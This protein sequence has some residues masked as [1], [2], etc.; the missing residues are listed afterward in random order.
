MS[1]Y[2]TIDAHHHFWDPDNGDYSWMSAAH[3]PIRRVFAPND[4]QP[5]LA[6]AG[7][8]KTI[9]V[10][11]WSSIDETLAFLKIAQETD[12]IAGVVGWLDLTAKD[13]SGRL[14]W[15]LARP[16]GKWLVGIRHQVHDEDDPNWLLRDDVRRGLS[17]IEAC[18]LTYDLLIRPRELSASL[19]TVRAF[20]GLRFVVDHIAKP[21]IGRGEFE[22]WA[23]KLR[24]LS[25][26]RGHVW[27]KLS[28]MVTEADWQHWKPADIAPFLHE[29]ISIF[30]VDRCLL[31]SDWPVCLLAASYADTIA[32][33]RNAIAGLPAAAQQSVLSQSAISAYKLDQGR[34]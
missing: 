31:G 18:G 8:S 34:L 22:E 28:G 11:T 30:G 4:L 13:V 21:D 15:V 27:C 12:F 16:E 20:P 32:L 33:V 29:A 7:I 25:Q 2:F 1:Q 6:A 14:D 5:E 26:E 19:A 24:P 9:L 10:Q 3:T 23:V 17:A